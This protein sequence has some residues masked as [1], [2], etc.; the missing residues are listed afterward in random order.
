M[1]KTQSCIFRLFSLYHNENVNTI[2]AG[3]VTAAVGIQ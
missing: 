1:D 3:S 2:F